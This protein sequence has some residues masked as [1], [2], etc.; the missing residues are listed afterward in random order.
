[1]MT[2]AVLVEPGRL[3]LA[4]VPAPDCA[5]GEVLV[6][7]AG[8]GLCGTDLA[9]FHGRRAVPATPWVLGHEGVGEIVATGSGVVDRTVG[10]RVV[11][12]PDICCFRCA[13][14]RRGLTSA[15][16]DRAS[17]GLT[18]PGLLAEYAA[19]PAGF[20]FPVADHVAL[21][22]LVCAEPLTVARAALRRSGIRAG[23]SCLV[24]GAGPQG[25]F[26]TMALVAAGV[27]PRVSEPD[28]DRLALA[29][30][31]GAVDAADSDEPV[32]H[33]FEASGVPAALATGV[34]RVAPGGTIVVVGMNSEPLAVRTDDLV[35]RQLTV[36]GSMIFDHPADFA[37]TVD[38]LDRGLLRPGRVLRREFPLARTA[39]A[40]AAMPGA[41]GK[42]WIRC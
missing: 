8:V 33:V 18:R 38:V 32:G 4:T 42:C 25:L 14:C 19:V 9:V 24:L 35:R 39:E 20:T 37:A 21:E 12:D 41:P 3:D 11:I 22:D 17:V 5:P 36:V 7:L 23:D 27:R 2:A 28:P 40:F 34:R 31:L 15:C 16:V 29:L 6:R 30:S 1:M 26:L 13:P 10:Q